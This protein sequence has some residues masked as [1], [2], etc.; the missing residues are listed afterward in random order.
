M[1]TDA[2]D[3]QSLPVLPE[4]ADHVLRMALEDD[5]SVAKLSG[6]IEKDQ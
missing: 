5:A 4:L 1:I 2:F 3:A 6:I